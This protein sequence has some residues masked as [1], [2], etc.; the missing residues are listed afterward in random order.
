VGEK[1]GWCVGLTTLPPSRADCL[2][3][4]EPEPPGTS[5]PVIGLY[6]GCFTFTFTLC[7]KNQTLF[8]I[9]AD[10]PTIS[11]PLQVDFS[12]LSKR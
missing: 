8:K 4:W 1:D 6:R 11:L 7:Y 12:I 3:I 9:K 2:E 5:G 10:Y